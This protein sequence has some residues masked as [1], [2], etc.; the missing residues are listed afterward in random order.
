L[1]DKNNSFLTLF[2]ELIYFILVC[3][4]YCFNG[5]ICTE[6][7]AQTPVE[8]TCECDETKY[9]GSRCQSIVT[10]TTID[11]PTTTTDIICTYLPDGYCTVGS[12]VV[13]GG[14]AKCKCP[15]THT[16]DQCQIVIGGTRIFYSFKIK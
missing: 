2:I 5:G 12:C 8:P 1:K 3:Y 7:T 10:T 16:G 14:L 6:D 4:N 13:I 9:T 15:S 11:P